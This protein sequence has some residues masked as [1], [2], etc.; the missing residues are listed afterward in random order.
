M[1][2]GHE[3]QRFVKCKQSWPGNLILLRLC[4]TPWIIFLQSWAAFAIQYV[5]VSV[6]YAATCAEVFNKALVFLGLTAT[7]RG[8][9]VWNS[10]TQGR[11]YCGAW[12]CGHTI[13]HDHRR[14][15]NTLKRILAFNAH[16]HIMERCL[17]W[18][19]G[20]GVLEGFTFECRGH[21]PFKLAKQKI[22]QEGELQVLGCKLSR[23]G[24]GLGLSMTIMTCLVCTLVSTPVSSQL[25]SFYISYSFFDMHGS[26]QPA[27][28][29]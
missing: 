1:L 23:W 14:H 5:E 28:L 18:G 15:T 12:D 29:L 20:V 25:T 13:S 2:Y 9:A 27:W 22:C 17:G 11:V 26:S 4:F 8:L 21:K 16:I 3:N 24:T 7:E 19:E 6:I 10:L